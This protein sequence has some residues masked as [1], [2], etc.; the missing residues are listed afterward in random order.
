MSVFGEDELL[1]IPFKVVVLLIA[2]CPFA[3]FSG[4]LLLTLWLHYEQAVS[5]HCGV[6][7]WLP[8][9][10]AAV[11]YAP[12]CY[13]WRF[14]IGIQGTP[15]MGLAFAS[16]NFLLSSGHWPSPFR[17]WF[18]WA[19]QFACALNIGEIIFLLLLTC[20]SSIENHD[21]HVFCFIIFA[22]CAILHMLMNTWLYHLSGRRR[23]SKLGQLSFHYKFVCTIGSVVSLLLALYFFYRHN[24]YCEPGVYTL[25]ALAEY[26]LIVFNVLFH[27]TLYYDFHSR[28][29]SLATAAFTSSNYDLLPMHAHDYSA[30]RGT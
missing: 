2:V 18:L 24:R 9:L 13:V 4:C 16:K 6:P 12:E 19:C 20:I 15:R 8:S 26:S 30:K 27:S 21:I 1:S 28:A 3:A 23:S 7:N 22:N 17:P 10:S 11:A 25:F 14:F 5:T 29:F